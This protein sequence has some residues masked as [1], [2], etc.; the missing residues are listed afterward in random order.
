MDAQARSRRWYRRLLHLYPRP[1][2][3]RFADSMEQTFA[4][5]CRE[6]AG[7]GVVLWIFTETVASIIR[8]RATDLARL[9]MTR[10][11]TFRLV[12]FLALAVGALTVAGI[13]AVMLLARGTEE[14]ITGVVAPALLLTVLSA[15]AAVVAGILQGTS[16]RR[17]HKPGDDP[18][19]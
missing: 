18:A 3:E 4:D 8:E 5:L 11:G 6:R 9:A 14:D 13:A 12:K 1:Y 16:G 7:A 15:V 10:T 19:G 17:G 2:R